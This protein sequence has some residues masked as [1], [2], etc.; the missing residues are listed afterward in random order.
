MADFAVRKLDL[1]GREALTYPG[2]VLAR[3]ANSIVVEAFFARA[4]RLELGYT[5]FER[6]DRFI[7]YFFADRWFNVFEVRAAG[8]GRLRGWYCNITRPAVIEAERVSA[9]DLALDVW[10]DPNRQLLVL[11]QAEFEA[12]PLADDE[13]ASARAAVDEIRRWA[14][15][16]RPPFDSG[17]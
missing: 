11:D 10:V 3:T 6:G 14:A 5:A 12:L 4:D 7:E 16:R 9:V 17:P 13:R 15:E 8:S 1:A 2:V